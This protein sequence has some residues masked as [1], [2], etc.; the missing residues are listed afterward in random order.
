M[1]RPD[2][3]SKYQ[4]FFERPYISI[5]KPSAYIIC[6]AR[7]VAA[8]PEKSVIYGI[9]EDQEYTF[10]NATDIISAPNQF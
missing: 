1:K 8:H 7:K 10:D 5:P 3:S 9:P 2:I 4:P 6:Y